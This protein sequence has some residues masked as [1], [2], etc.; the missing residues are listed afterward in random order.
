MACG[1]VL[2]RVPLA[3]A[4]TDHAGDADSNARLYEG[5]PWSVRL[6]AKL[7]RER[8]RGNASPWQP[9]VRALPQVVPC[10]LTTW[11]W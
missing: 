10:P 7:L 5:A 4:L 8:A 9:Y 6:A 2:L 11:S 1:T 3:L